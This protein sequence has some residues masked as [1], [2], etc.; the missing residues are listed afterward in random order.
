MP[1]GLISRGGEGAYKRDFT[2]FILV[3]YIKPVDR[4]HESRLRAVRL[5]S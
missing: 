2:V 1:G 5:F 3:D 4:R